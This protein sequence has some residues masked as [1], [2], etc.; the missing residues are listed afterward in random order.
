M[1]TGMSQFFGSRTNA[2]PDAGAP[3]GNKPAL[4][5][6]QFQILPSERLL[7]RNGQRVDIGSRAF[8]LL[9]V[10]VQARGQVVSRRDIVTHV[11]PDTVVA[12]ENLRFQMACLRAVLGNDRDVIKTVPRRGYLL[13]ADRHHPPR[14]AVAPWNS[15]LIEKCVPE[16]S[17]RPIVAVIDDDRATR[18][19]LDGLLRS[20]GWSVE[21]F[22]SVKE[23]VQA[24]RERPPQCIVLDVWMPGRSGLEFQEDLAQAG[25]LVPL[26]FISGHADVPMSVR[27]MKAG[28][29]EFLVKPVRH[30]E[31][32]AAVEATRTWTGGNRTA[33]TSLLSA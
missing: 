6:R 22:G 7:L 20:A 21:L 10:L 24:H 27:A 16:A 5:F 28:A 14:S 33:S 31:F 18:E 23:Y 3:V 32:L 25:L 4:R 1:N 11:W 19:A 2:P 15:A 12:D 26:I 17:A 30:E 8:D 29:I 9:L 13:V